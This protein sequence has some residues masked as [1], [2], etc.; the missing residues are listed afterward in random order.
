M[1]GNGRFI[2]ILKIVVR[3]TICVNSKASREMTTPVKNKMH[4][5]RVARTGIKRLFGQS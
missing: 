3:I 5:I 4:F 1:F 2:E